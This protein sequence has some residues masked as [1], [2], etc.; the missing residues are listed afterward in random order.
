MELYSGPSLSPKDELAIKAIAKNYENG[1]ILKIHALHNADFTDEEDVPGGLLMIHPTDAKVHS[2]S[3]PLN[4]FSYL[5]IVPIISEKALTDADFEGKTIN[6]NQFSKTPPSLKCQSL[7]GAKD[8][9]IWNPEFGEDEHAFAGVF[10]QTKGRESR[11]FI[12]VQAGAPMACKQLRD[13]ISRKNITF[14]ELIHDPDYNYCHYIAQR[15]AQRIAYNV[16][17]SL[18]VPIRHMADLSSFKEYE[19]SALPMRAVPSYTQPT[20]TILPIVHESQNA[21]GVFNKLSPVGNAAPTHFVYQGPW[22][23]ISVYHLKSG[24][25]GHALPA[26]SGKE[27]GGKQLSKSEIAKRAQTI[28]V[29]GDIKKHPDII[30]ESYKAADSEEFMEAMKLSGWR[31]QNLHNLVPVLIKIYDPSVKR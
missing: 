8:G 21:I 11:Y 25:I 6:V 9:K 7:D 14:E 22:N 3:L 15:N 27:L 16:A 26:H 29:E 2:D 30:S 28:H 1:K 10:K 18:Q 23:G 5:M 4:A 20:S 24:A 19:Y 12:G 17:S 31:Q 13:K